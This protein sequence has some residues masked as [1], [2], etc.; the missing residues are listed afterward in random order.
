MLPSQLLGALAVLVSSANAFKTF[1]GAAR[2]SAQQAVIPGQFIVQVAASSLLKRD[3]ADT[4]LDNVLNRLRS[5]PR[6]KAK[7]RKSYREPRLFTGAAITVEAA[8]TAEDI[9]SVEGVE[10]VWPVRRVSRPTPVYASDS[11]ASSSS[12]SAPVS[13][14]QLLTLA[15]DNNATL[16]RRGSTLSRRSTAATD[17]WN[18]HVMGQVDVAHTK[19]WTGQ[20]VKIGII[21]TGVDWKHPILNLATSVAPCFGPGCLI[22]F[23][24]DFVGDNA[25]AGAMDPDPYTDCTEHG[26][27][28]TGIV[29]A[30]DNSF[31][32]SGV[33][34]GAQIGHYRVFGCTGE[35]STDV[36]VEALMR[37]YQD[38]CNIVSLSLGSSGGWVDSDPSSVL[39]AKLNSLGV[40]TTVSAGNERTEGLFWTDAPAATLTG[41]SVGSVDVTSLPA[42]TANIL[43][44]GTI[45]ILAALPL[46]ITDTLVVYFLSTDPT[47]TDDGCDALPA[48]LDL[49]GK[50]VVIQRGTCLFTDKMSNA[51]AAGARVAL[52]YN[53]ATGGDM[54]YFGTQDTGL[55]AVASMRRE[56]GLKLLAFYKQN[57]R[58]LRMNFPTGPLA[59]DA[60]NTISGGL[61]SEFSNSGPTN[62]LYGQ[63]SLVAP[64]GSIF[65]TIPLALGGVDI[66]SG[67]SMAAPYIAGASA[68]LLSARKSEKLTPAQVRSL[69]VTTAKYTTSSLESGS[70]LETTVLQGGGLVQVV[71]AINAKTLITPYELQLND[72]AYFK[73][74]QTITLENR[75]PYAV[76][77]T[78]S[79]VASRSL[80]AYDKAAKTSVLPSLDPQEI[81]AAASVSFGARVVTV[82]A[83]KTTNVKVTIKAPT[84]SA[85]TA[86]RFP[87]YSGFLIINQAASGQ[88]SQRYTVPYFGVAARMFDAP[89]L[90]STST[91]S[92]NYETGL[93]YPFLTD[94][95][96]VQVGPSSMAFT[97]SVGVTLFARLAQG[98]RMVT[99]DLVLGSSTFI[100]TIPSTN[101]AGLATRMLR[102]SP[103]SSASPSSSLHDTSSLLD[104]HDF[105]FDSNSTDF[106]SE[107]NPL[108][109]RAAG[110]S[111]PLYSAT[112][113]LGRIYTGTE[114]PRDYAVENSGPAWSDAQITFHGRYQ[115]DPTKPATVSAANSKEYRLLLRALKI[116]G[117]PLYEA[118]WESFLS[119]PFTFSS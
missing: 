88:K 109:R 9:L 53:S 6:V 43:L 64:G 46:P 107:L 39:V 70:S 78:F 21:D 61:V 79:H 44:R 72:T 47:K 18:P 27:H 119:P 51:A 71:D 10:R 57:P 26:T 85:A 1:E 91:Y 100:P 118:S 89:I 114:L 45:P 7:P 87:V 63:P 2:D 83:G 11:P 42:Y 98:T 3:E 84:I 90:D 95:D 12:T 34:K 75:N 8:V 81:N 74:V 80:G 92:G 77:Y 48:G 101:N 28:V 29:A 86:S 52:I 58:S 96:R 15:E 14:E 35:S 94:Y 5:A 93:K 111:G 113:I 110:S 68:L 41:I 65:S 99:V 24:Y 36:V 73:G 59:T 56:D 116:T 50:V 16:F 49:S 20:G 40:V 54:P 82:A 67:T 38:G 104:V 66:L 33:A 62:E 17:T 22:S 76:K 32:F 31:G 103:N 97:K 69:L 106:S 117:N 60:T 37:A 102:R 13:A 112:S 4:V 19:G 55:E 105:S 23:G 108:V 30:Q 25:N 115:P